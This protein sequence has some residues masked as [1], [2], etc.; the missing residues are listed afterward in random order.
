MK[1]N[2]M[3]ADVN[4]ADIKSSLLNEVSTKRIARQKSNGNL[5]G[6]WR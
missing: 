2:Q 1:H 4:L 3:L 6:S 5:I